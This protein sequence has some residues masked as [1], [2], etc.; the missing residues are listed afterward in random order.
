MFSLQNDLYTFL[1][2]LHTTSSNSTAYKLHCMVIDKPDHLETYT[3]A[4]FLLS[5][6]GFEIFWNI[7]ILP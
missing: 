6:S 2:K 1:S 7:P 4:F 5:I 3:I